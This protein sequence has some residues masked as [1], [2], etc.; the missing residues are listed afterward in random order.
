MLI[1]HV[2]T[3]YYPSLGGLERVVQRLAEAQATLGHEIHVITSVHRAGNRPKEEQIGNVHIHRIRA[4]TPH[5][6]D[7]TIPREIPLELLKRANIVQGWS[8]NSFFTYNIIKEA[9][10]LGKPVAMYFLGVDYLRDHYNPLIRIFGYKYQTWITRRVAKIVNLALTTNEFE[11]GVLKE[12]Y[13]IEAIVVPHGVDEAYLKTPNM[14]TYLREKYR[15]KERI[16]SYIARIHPTKGLDLLI[17]AFAE[18]VKHVPDAVLVVAGKGDEGYL[19][20]CLKTA[21]KLGIRDRVRY[22]GYI[23]E[24][25]KIALIDASEVVVLPTR[26]AGESYPLLLDEVVSRGK[27]MIVTNVSKALASRAKELGL[28]VTPPD[29][30]SLA[31]SIVKILHNNYTYYK[32]QKVYTWKEIAQKLLKIYNSIINTSAVKIYT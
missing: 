16:V 31:L 26:H 8:Q 2:S 11:K 25:D 9:K 17:K 24:E 20:K 30:Q 27:P 6:P 15:I 7:L 23:P 14:A 12:K 10:R 19:K 1:V 29:A 13:G 18:A 3:Y 22:L 4:W 32:P 21:E 5:Y 28:I